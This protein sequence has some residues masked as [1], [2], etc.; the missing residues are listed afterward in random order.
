MHDV[1][2]LLTIFPFEPDLL[3]LPFIGAVI[4]WITN[5]LAVKMLFH[6]R[7]PL[8]LIFFTVQGVFP[9]R[10][11]ALAHKLGQVVSTELISAQDL[12]ESLAEK[13][14][15]EPMLQ[16][17]ADRIEQVI[18]QKLPAVIPMIAMVLSPEIVQT[19]KNAFM[20]DL[21]EMISD[22]ID[23]LSSEIHQELDVHAIV[24]EKV[25]NFSSAKLEE[26]LFAIMRREFRFIELV[27]AFLGFLI[28]VVQVALLTRELWI[29]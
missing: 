21:K 14:T 9:K 27:G 12:T 29:P 7:K 3:L 8:R 17:V 19:V 22:L 25:A 23:K 4:G 18:T 26:I 11:Q 1:Y 6:P 10:Q 20:E 16:V 24:E 13:A 2:D 28:G 5:Y 15:S